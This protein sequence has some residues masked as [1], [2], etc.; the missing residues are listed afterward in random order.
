MNSS[1]GWGWGFPP[2][3][4]PLDPG[5]WAC[6]DVPLKKF[7]TRSGQDGR[8][9][10]LG[11]TSL[12]TPASEHGSS[13]RLPMTPEGAACEGPNHVRAALLFASLPSFH[14]TRYSV[15]TFVHKPMSRNSY[16]IY[17]G[18]DDRTY[19]EHGGDICLNI[20]SRNTL[21]MRGISSDLQCEKTFAGISL[22]TWVECASTQSD[23]D[24]WIVTWGPC[25]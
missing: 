7:S 21:R 13:P 1:R 17:S 20:E 8:P 3:L 4:P 14:T 6:S 10:I 5:A 23:P 16:Y 12:D 11:H 18:L 15:K 19:K 24:G 9:G 25:L 22:Q 2:G